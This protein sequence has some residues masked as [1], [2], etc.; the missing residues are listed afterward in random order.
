[1][2]SVINHE[3]HN[4]LSTGFKKSS[5]D[6]ADLFTFY[7]QFNTTGLT[8][9]AAFA[10]YSVK[11][12]QME[13]APPEETDLNRKIEHEQ[14]SV[15]RQKSSFPEDE[16]ESLSFFRILTHRKK[17]P[18]EYVTQTPREFINALAFTEEETEC[19][20]EMV[21]P[22]APSL[23][24]WARVWPFFRTILGTTYHSDE[25]DIPKTI[26]IITECKPFRRFPMVQRNA[27]ASH[28]QILL[29]CDERM[30]PFHSDLY[31][32]M[33]NL[34]RIRGKSGMEIF[35][36]ENGPYK[37]M[38]KFHQP[39]HYVPYN[40]PEPGTPVV[41]VSDLGC[42]DSTGN[43]RNEW[44]HFGRDLYKKGFCPV[45]L[46]PLSPGMVDK[47]LLF[48]WR[49]VLLNRNKKLNYYNVIGERKPPEQHFA[50]VNQLL[51][52]L[53]AAIRVETG[54]LRSVRML[55]GPGAD[56]GVEGAVWNHSAVERTIL[57]FGFKIGA[58]RR[59]RE[60]YKEL[61]K[62]PGFHELQEK[63]KELIQKFHQPL[64]K[65]ILMEE[66]ANWGDIDTAW[67]KTAKT[68]MDTDF[69]GFLAW[70]LRVKERLS[71]ETWENDAIGAAW[72][73][74]HKDEILHNK[75]ITIPPGL[76][77]N[78]YEWILKR[79]K[80]A[81]KTY[82][83]TQAGRSIRIFPGSKETTHVYTITTSLPDIQVVTFPR[84]KTGPGEVLRLEDA[85]KEIRNLDPPPVIEPGE[86]NMIR[87]FTE[88]DV[89][90]IDEM[91]KPEWALAMGRDKNGLF[92]E[93]KT[94]KGSK[95]LY[96]CDPRTVLYFGDD[97]DFYFNKGFFWDAPEYLYF[98][99]NGFPA[100]PWAAH[101]GFDEYGLSATVTIK[102]VQFR[103]RWIKPG[104]FMLGS[105]ED[106]PER[107]DNET[108]HRVILTRGYWM[109]ETPCTREL[110]EVVMGS[111]PS[112]F[113]GK[114]LPVENVS[115]NDC[116][117]FIL[118][119]NTM[120]PGLEL[121]LPTEAEWEYA[122]RA[123]TAT[124]FHF[125]ENASTDQVNYDG[126]FPYNNGKKGEY[127]EKTVEV[128]AL[129]CNSWG[130]YQ[131]HGNVWEWCEDWYGEYET[132]TVIDPQGPDNG[133]YRVI[134]GG[135]WFGDARYARSAAR[136][137]GG[138]SFRSGRVGFRLARG[139]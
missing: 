102:N 103:M 36:M 5:V 128:F 139:Y 125:G 95:R 34:I 99:E 1:M 114:Q 18:E 67:W 71:A 60:N 132:G 94:E 126:N 40:T 80:P 7:R 41:V 17:S 86:N 104:E 56:A 84:E 83:L 129:P 135:G 66:R 61:Q 92:A 30:I 122:C 15:L 50:L 75:Q 87:L 88:H 82:F 119:I 62:D 138:P 38:R 54:L 107:F 59:F 47:E 63:T 43:S 6:L 19:E 109:A 42:F 111:N 14:N 32:L 49:V 44:L 27:W 29:D 73:I 9:M 65:M 72:V 91:T 57:G 79:E 26:R 96:W 77:L 112:R 20:E 31:R 2:K 24:V 46:V 58:S 52:L 33:K 130:L 121:R 55:L 120:I 68:L 105:P 110:W 10:N 131:I 4:A 98:K 101:H 13:T 100:L 137:G 136:N 118:K 23:L 8:T 89:F 124:P 81:E 39:H 51:T 48:Y 45:A 53:S 16:K 3:T 25:V 11:E 74:A 22:D 116:K 35:I 28:C 69:P 85:V 97:M 127:R 123:S 70:F 12:K 76:D 133:D 108:L 117:K 93:Y 37:K 106:E 113:K 90:D 64:S 21:I 134:R 115:W 78:L